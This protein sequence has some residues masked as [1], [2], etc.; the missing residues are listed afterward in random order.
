MTDFDEL[1]GVAAQPA[2]PLTDSSDRQRAAALRAAASGATFVQLR[3]L[4][5]PVTA[6]FLAS[7]FDMD[8]ATIKKRLLPLE[9][10][11]QVGGRQVVVWDFKEAAAYLVEPKID[12]E[13]Y[14]ASLD[15]K[16]LPHHI[17]KVFWDAKRSKLKYLHEAGEAWMTSDVLEV[18][19]RAFMTIKDQTQL[20]VETMRERGK[21]TD[22]QMTLFESLVDGFQADLHS[23]LVEAPRLHQTQSVAGQD[24]DLDE[25][26]EG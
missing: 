12:L 22:E 15:F 20:F 11:A 17:N 3:D 7:V 6:S 26:V 10:L 9:P 8:P 18:F 25:G 4:K 23:K 19:G 24:R 13:K 14:I 5:R 2:P 16:K 1:I 21:L